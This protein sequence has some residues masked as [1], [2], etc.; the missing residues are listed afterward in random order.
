[1]VDCEIARLTNVFFMRWFSVLEWDTWLMLIL[2]YSKP[3]IWCSI[4]E[5]VLELEMCNYVC[6]PQC[7]GLCMLNLP[8]VLSVRFMCIAD[9]YFPHSV[10]S[11]EQHLLNIIQLLNEAAPWCRTPGQRFPSYQWS[12]SR[13]HLS[14]LLQLSVRTH[15]FCHPRLGRTLCKA[16]WCLCS[17]MS[18]VSDREQMFDSLCVSG[19]SQKTQCEG[20]TRVRLSREPWPHD[21]HRSGV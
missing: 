16:N 19:K 15:P 2:G 10:V 14:V 1:M 7:R 5:T 21:T 13:L 20:Q 18:L 4:L 3:V 12:A 6:F 9:F 11:D 17:W 8:Q